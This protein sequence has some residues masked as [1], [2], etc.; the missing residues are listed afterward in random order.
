MDNK[1][2]ALAILAKKPTSEDDKAPKSDDMGLDAAVSDLFDA[3]ENKDQDAFK[4]A[5][6]NAVSMCDSGDYSPKDEE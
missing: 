3:I 5:F 4:E 6:K 1:G 2:I